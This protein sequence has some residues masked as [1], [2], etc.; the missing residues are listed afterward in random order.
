MPPKVL[1]LDPR[2]WAAKRQEAIEKANKL[3]ANRAVGGILDESYTFAPKTNLHRKNAS[4]DSHTNRQLSIDVTQSPGANLYFAV[5]STSSTTLLRSSSSMATA[6]R[7]I[8]SMRCSRSSSNSSSGTGAD[9]HR[10][11]NDSMSTSDGRGGGGRSAR[12][13][14]TAAPAPAKAPGTFL[15][16]LRTTKLQPIYTHTSGNKSSSTSSASDVSTK[17]HQLASSLSWSPNNYEEDQ[18]SLAP[19]SNPLPVSSSD[20]MVGAGPTGGL[21]RKKAAAATSTA[22]ISTGLFPRCCCC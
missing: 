21:S 18:H 15:P 6:R 2:Q 7:S 16:S 13:A 19:L 22:A 5:P 14:A 3:R 8:S 4:G 9:H 12:G 20:A 17:Q 1:F 11:R 10:G